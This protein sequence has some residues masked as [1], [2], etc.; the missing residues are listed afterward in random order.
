MASGTHK[1][2]GTFIGTGVAKEISLD[3][4]PRWVRLVN[5]TDLESAEK[6]ADSDVATKEG[7]VSI[8]ATGAMT[9]LTAAQGITLGERKF[10]VGTDNSVNGA[11]DHISYIAEE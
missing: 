5:L 10:T 11:A 1:K 2:V 6:Y 7:G 8:D 3:F 4:T 9:A